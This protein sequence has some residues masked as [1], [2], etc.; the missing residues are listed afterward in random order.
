MLC[1]TPY[2][3][4]QLGLML[5]HHAHYASCDSCITDSDIVA[6]A[7]R[8]NHK[9]LELYRL[10]VSA[11]GPKS[12]FAVC[13]NQPRGASG[14]IYC[15]SRSDAEGLAVHLRVSTACVKA[16]KPDALSGVAIPRAICCLIVPCC[17]AYCQVP[18][19]AVFTQLSIN[20]GSSV[21]CC[22]PSDFWGC[23]PMQPAGLDTS[24]T[25]VP[26]SFQH[27]TVQACRSLVQCKPNYIRQP[28][29][30]S[31]AALANMQPLSL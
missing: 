11:E 14:I 5:T 24:M 15:L 9:G 17:C 23:H 13:R 29:L 6:D 7:S 26:S 20:I 4:K 28:V 19:H 18:F 3:F 16:G 30:A 8:V 22:Q 2:L 31:T 10:C 25:T 27:H 1:T 12:W 21:L